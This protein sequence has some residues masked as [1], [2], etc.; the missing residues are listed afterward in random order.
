MEAENADLASELRTVTNAK[1]ESDRR[2]KQ[3]EQQLSELQSKMGENDRL[4]VEL[5]EK[6]AKLQQESDS[7][8]AQV[9]TFILFLFTIHHCSVS[10]CFI[11]VI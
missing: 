6:A 5:A 4:R 7:I 2:R 11:C 8:T 3:A 10:Y 9:G 1:Q